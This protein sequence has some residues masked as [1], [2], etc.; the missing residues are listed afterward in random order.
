MTTNNNQPL[1]YYDP[2][3]YN[4]V[5]KF[6]AALMAGQALSYAIL[7]GG[8]FCD[9]IIGVELF[10]V[11]QVAFFSISNIDNVQPLLSPLL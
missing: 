6:R 9:K 4:E 1:T 2:K 7:A 8:M 11:W 10:G 3:T 5:P